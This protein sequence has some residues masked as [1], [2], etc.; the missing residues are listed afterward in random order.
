[1]DH[2]SSEKQRRENMRAGFQKL[3]SLV[4]QLRENAGGTGFS[5]YGHSVSKATILMKSVEY[6]Y[7]LERK[8]AKYQE[9]I[10]EMEEGL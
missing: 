5:D 1:M 4:P 3:V 8:I 6:I 2:P 10:Q 9:S 7:L